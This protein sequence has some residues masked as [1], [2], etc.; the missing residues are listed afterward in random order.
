MSDQVPQ[1]EANAPKDVP[2]ISNKLYDQLMFLAVV[3]LP[4][5][6]ALYFGIAAIWG[7]PKA[8][9]LVGTITVI[10]TFLGGVLLKLRSDYNNSDAKY[11][12]VVPADAVPPELEGRKEVLFKVEK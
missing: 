5:V 7:L 2:V 11:D 6:G 1:A 8:E 10:D 9:E 4:A 12:G 3:L